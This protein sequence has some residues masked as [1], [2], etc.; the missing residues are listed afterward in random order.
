MTLKELLIQELD[1]TSELLLVEVLDFLQF[2][3]SKQAEDAADVV[4]AR[5]ALATVAAEG[6]VAWESLKADVGL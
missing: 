4:D 6:T 2:L 3:K 5:Q 1:D